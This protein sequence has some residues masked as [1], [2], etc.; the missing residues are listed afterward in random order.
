MELYHEIHAAFKLLCNRAGS[1][2]LLK[3]E[4][5][6]KASYFEKSGKLAFSSRRKVFGIRLNPDAHC[7]FKLLCDASGYGKVNEAIEKIMVK[8]IEQG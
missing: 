6:R 1:T 8:C 5:R 4:L 3:I 7:A 2:K